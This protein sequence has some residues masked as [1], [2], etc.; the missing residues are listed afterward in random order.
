MSVCGREDDCRAALV[1]HLQFIVC[2]NLR[3]YFPRS[4]FWLKLLRSKW[5]FYVSVSALICLFR[6][7]ILIDNFF[8]HSITKSYRSKKTRIA[9]LI[10]VTLRFCRGHCWERH[11][12]QY[13]RSIKLFFFSYFLFSFPADNHRRWISFMFALSRWKRAAEDRR[14]ERSTVMST[15]KVEDEKQNHLTRHWFVFHMHTQFPYYA[16]K[17]IPKG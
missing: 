14:N 10:N 15:T 5:D 7:R 9:H 17:S 4:F 1:H 2:R 6:K 12:S 13:I 16:S 8:F 11:R 3:F